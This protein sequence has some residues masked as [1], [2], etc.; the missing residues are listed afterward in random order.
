MSAVY[1]G[2]FGNSAQLPGTNAS[3]IGS[4]AYRQFVQSLVFGSLIPTEFVCLIE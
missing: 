1:S 4:I 2:A 3:N